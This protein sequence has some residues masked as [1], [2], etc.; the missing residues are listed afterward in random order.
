MQVLICIVVLVLWYIV[1]LNDS[2]LSKNKWLYK[3]FMTVFCV[4]RTLDYELNFI[5]INSFIIQ[6]ISKQ[7]NKKRKATSVGILF[8][9]MPNGYY[10]KGQV[11]TCCPAT[12]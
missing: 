1:V 6:S 5:S 12:H 2:S 10:A 9:T 7:A 3:T 8:N 4:I 11:V